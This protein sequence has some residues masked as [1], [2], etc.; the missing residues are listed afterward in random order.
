MKLKVLLD[1][2]IYGLIIEQDLDL[3]ESIPNCRDIVVY[4]N[5][6]IR[7][8]LRETPKTKKVQATKS[9]RMLLLNNFDLL[10]G[11]HIIPTTKKT[12][13]LAREYF[14]QY[15]KSAG[16]KSWREIKNDFL[17]VASAALKDLDIVASEDNK[18]M[19][20]KKAMDSYQLA[21]GK[22][23]LRTPTFFSYK[24]FKKIVR[25]CDT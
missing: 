2:N 5:N 23:F 14:K 3:V 8:E 19:K 10:V 11:K 18:T 22:R 25:S 21:N 15:K 1:T 16:A 20:S 6:T 7:K 17:I 4:G 9:Y 13:K 24:N 12:E